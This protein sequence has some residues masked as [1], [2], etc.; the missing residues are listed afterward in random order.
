MYTCRQAELI[1]HVVCLLSLKGGSGK[2]TVVQSLSVC[3]QQHGHR[4]LIV[5]LDPQGTLKNWSK[6]RESEH[7]RVVQTLPQSVG[8]VLE[9]ARAEG[10]RWVFLDTPGHH[11]AS[12][13]AAAELADLIL[14]P[15]KIQSVKDFDAVLPSLAEA[16][17]ADKPAYVLMNQ[18]PP[19]SPRLIRRRQLQIQKH[20]DIAV[21]S[22]FLCRRADFEYCDE[23]G[24]SAAELNPAGPAAEEIDRL[25]A[26]LQSIF[27]MRSLKV[28]KQALVPAPGTSAGQA[29]RSGEVAARPLERGPARTEEL[30]Q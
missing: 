7:P 22:R 26:L 10:V 1:V 13:S 27:I 2:S 6:R 19:N 8:D 15:C 12:A 17:R 28:D 30:A 3:A 25:Y 24:M 9:E 5:E 18:V 14:I 21:L 20:Y 4:T 29:G 16:R 23:R 11:V